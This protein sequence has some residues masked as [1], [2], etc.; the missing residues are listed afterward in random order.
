M[1]IV[2]LFMTFYITIPL[3]FTGYLFGACLF[4]SGSMMFADLQ[5]LLGLFFGITVLWVYTEQIVNGSLRFLIENLFSLSGHYMVS[6]AIL[7]FPLLMMVI[8]FLILI[9]P[10]E[11][12]YSPSFSEHLIVR[13]AHNEEGEHNFYVEKNNEICSCDPGYP[14]P[15]GV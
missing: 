1:L 12:K 6:E 2:L 8:V 9:N 13:N 7:S 14:S 3:V 4:R 10:W 15:G 11:S 5:K